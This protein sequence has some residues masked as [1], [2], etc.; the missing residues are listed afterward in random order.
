M[1]TVTSWMSVSGTGRRT[2]Y[3]GA[4]SLG[5]SISGAPISNMV[6][7]VFHSPSTAEM[8]AFSGDVEWGTYFT[9]RIIERISR[10]ELKSPIATEERAYEF[11]AHSSA[12]CPRN[13]I[14]DIEIVYGARHGDDAECEFRLF[15][16]SCRIHENDSWKIRRVGEDKLTSPKSVQVYSG[17][18]GGSEVGLRHKWII[19]GDQGDVARASFWTLC[20]LVDG[21]PRKDLMTGGFPQLT[22]IDCSG[23]A[24]PVGVKYHCIAT[25]FGRP[26][27][28]PKDSADFWVDESFTALNPTSL[29]TFSSAQRYGRPKNGR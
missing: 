14:T 12:R 15:L 26:V 13:A 5:S 25:V 6:K 20:D 19:G 27:S 7:K 21:V 4:D 2:F 18:L 29:K 11:C 23:P 1:T 9:S 22:K 10:G 17:G 16:L 24:H 28:S 3:L 8:F